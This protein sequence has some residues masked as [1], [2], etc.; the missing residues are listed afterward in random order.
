MSFVLSIAFG[1][2]FSSCISSAFASTIPTRLF[3]SWINLLTLF[4]S[5]TRQI[6]TASQVYPNLI[7]PNCGARGKCIDEKMHR[8][9]NFSANRE[10][11][12]DQEINYVNVLDRTLR[13]GNDA[14]H[15]RGVTR[16][17]DGI[18]TKCQFQVTG[19][20]S[21]GG[22]VTDG[23]PRSFHDDDFIELRIENFRFK[24]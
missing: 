23:I 18:F 22:A 9:A 4:S 6:Y 14:A 12:P 3:K 13:F 7:R 1:G 5:I 10:I 20:N 15:T 8:H 24:R 16:T 2:S 17:V 11:S 19:K 21:A